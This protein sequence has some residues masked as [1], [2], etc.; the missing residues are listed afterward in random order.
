MYMYGGSLDPMPH[1][2]GTRLIRGVLCIYIHV[3]ALIILL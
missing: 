1:G 2:L 3:L